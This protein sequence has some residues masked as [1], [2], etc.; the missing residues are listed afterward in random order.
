M[1]EFDYAADVLLDG[2]VVRGEAGFEEADVEDHIYVVGSVAE[3]ADG[4]VAFGAGGDG[5]EGEADDAANGNAG[6]GKCGGGDGDPGGV[7]H[8]AG[9]AVFGG[10]VAELE[11]L[12]AG[13][14]GLEE[15]MVED[16]GEVFAGREGVSGEGDGVKAGEGGGGEGAQTMLLELRCVELMTRCRWH[17]TFAPPSHLSYGGYGWLAA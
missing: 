7:D 14:V 12:G 3:H 16:G 2:F 5:A 9:E 8:G 1:G 10:F 11:D 15:G 17:G 4:F 13:G 6:S